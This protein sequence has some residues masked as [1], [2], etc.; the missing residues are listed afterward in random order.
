[1][2]GSL[3]KPTLTPGLTVEVCHTVDDVRAI[4]FM[5][6][7][8]RVYAT[9]CIVHDLEYA[10]RDLILEHLEEGQDSVGARVEIEHLKPTPIGF[11][12]RHVITVEEVNSRSVT[13]S[14]TVHDDLEKVA[15]ARH[16]RFVVDVAR[17]KKMVAQKRDAK[18]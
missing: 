1:M 4:S 5:G 6:D 17:L 9:P 14:V 7:D 8:L 3:M 12:V 10:C 11:E 13:C 18:G 2:Q 15:T 16:T